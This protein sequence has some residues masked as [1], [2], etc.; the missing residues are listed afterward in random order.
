MNIL[1]EMLMVV[2]AYSTKNEDHEVVEFLLAGFIGVLR[3]WWENSLNV[4]ELKFIKTSIKETI[5][6][7]NAVHILVYTVS[8]HFIGDNKILQKRNF[9]ILQ[10]LRCTTLS[11]FQWYHNVFVSQVMTI[12]DARASYWK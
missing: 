11:D 8:K 4:E 3:E 12:S 1:H 6:E 10:N 9:E 2:I 7:Q 5:G